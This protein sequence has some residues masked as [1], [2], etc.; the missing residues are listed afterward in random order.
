MHLVRIR[1]GQELTNYGCAIL[2]LENIRLL[3]LLHHICVVVRVRSRS[4]QP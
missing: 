3:L 1:R 2:L 4:I